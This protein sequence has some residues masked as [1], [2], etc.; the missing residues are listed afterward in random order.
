MIVY[1]LAELSRLEELV[2]SVNDFSQRGL[3]VGIYSLINLKVLNMWSCGLSY[4]DDRL[5]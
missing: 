3:P 2:I 4:I 1:R 5:V